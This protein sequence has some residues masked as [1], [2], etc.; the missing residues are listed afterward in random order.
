MTS[1]ST[2]FI[3][4]GKRQVYTRALKIYLETQHLAKNNFFLCST[5]LLLPTTVLCMHCTSI[6]LLNLHGNSLRY[7]E[8]KNDLGKVTT[9]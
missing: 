4:C 3:P 2:H 9:N 8:I 6:I 1:L 7:R 5:L